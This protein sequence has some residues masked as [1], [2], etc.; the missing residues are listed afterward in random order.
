MKK[1]ITAL[2]LLISCNLYGQL[3][4][5]AGIAQNYFNINFGKESDYFYGGV[6]NQSIGPNLDFEWRFKKYY[7]QKKDTV[8]NLSKLSMTIHKSLLLGVH[9]TN[10]QHTVVGRNIDDDKLFSDWNNQY[11]HL[12]LMFKIN[13]QPF[14]L[15]ENFHLS[16]GIGVVNSFLLSSTLEENATIFTLDSNG[17]IIDE[18]FIS[19]SSN[20]KPYMNKY[21]HML[22][23]EMSGSFKRLYIG[24]R[25]WNSI[26][27][28]YME[29]LE[30][31]WLLSNQ[32]SVYLG[33]Y[34][35]WDKISYSGGGFVMSWKLN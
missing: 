30:G 2:A 7:W 14:I 25:A 34:Q 26:T 9:Y 19:A 1:L 28:Q 21:L 4:I 22:G 33:S 23:I 11:L 35:T 16:A 13:F 10:H 3:D 12:P 31:D 8:M 17:E 29:G 24:I 5:R 18:Q 6:A 27:D 15:D 32:Y 20:V